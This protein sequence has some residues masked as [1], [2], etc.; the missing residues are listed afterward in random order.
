MAQQVAM[1]FPCGDNT[2]Q[3]IMMW[4]SNKEMVQELTVD[5]VLSCFEEIL[6]GFAKSLQTALNLS[7]Q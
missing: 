1:G 5:E 4:P 2:L 6:Q 7:S 3:L